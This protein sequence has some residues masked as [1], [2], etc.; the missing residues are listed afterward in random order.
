MLDVL[1]KNGGHRIDYFESGTEIISDAAALYIRAE[2]P[3]DAHYDHQAK[4][5]LYQGLAIISAKIGF[6]KLAGIYIDVNNLENLERPAYQRM[7]QDLLDGMFRRIYVLDSNA[8]LGHPAAD[9]DLRDLYWSA[10]G[11][12]LISYE[13]G[14]AEPLSICCRDQAWA[15]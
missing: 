11:F 6:Q 5:Q 10:G 4:H 9:A 8:I 13:N 2:M 14:V 15:V 3:D 7:K 12:E 1:M